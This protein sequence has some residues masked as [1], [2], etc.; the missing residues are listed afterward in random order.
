[1]GMPGKRSA[2]TRE[3]PHRKL[4]AFKSK[5]RECDYLRIHVNWVVL[6]LKLI[7]TSLFN[8]LLSNTQAALLEKA[9][10][11]IESYNRP[12]SARTIVFCDF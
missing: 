5:D 8:P 6:Y 4:S 2:E 3:V 10:S 12:L 1:M 7:A 11:P 9:L